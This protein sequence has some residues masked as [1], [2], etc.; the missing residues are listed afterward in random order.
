LSV[1]IAP[2]TKTRTTPTRLKAKVAALKAAR[3]P[4][5]PLDQAVANDRELSAKV[6]ENASRLRDKM[7]ARAAKNAYEPPRNDPLAD[8]DIFEEIQRSL[9]RGHVVRLTSRSPSPVIS[10]IDPLKLSNSADRI[11]R[12]EKARIKAG[13]PPGIIRRR[14]PVHILDWEAI[15]KID[16][17]RRAKGEVEKIVWVPHWDR[18]GHMLKTFA[19]SMAVWERA[20]AVMSI[21]IADNVI[22]AAQ[23]DRRGFAAHMRERLKRELSITATRTGFDAPEFFFVVEASQLGRPHLHGGITLPTNEGHRK[24]IRRALFEAAYGKARRTK[25]TG[26]EVEDATGQPTNREC[27]SKTLRGPPAG[28]TGGSAG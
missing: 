15:D 18:T 17:A 3:A 16:R 20:G 24:A 23:R 26:R 13:E 9:R 12:E 4:L 19:W 7:A 1:E 11:R 8:R 27:D 21:N 6:S 5:R 28:G 25:P 22:A 14:L 2:V 10:G